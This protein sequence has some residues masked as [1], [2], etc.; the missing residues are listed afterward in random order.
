MLFS[1]R[2]FTRTTP[3]ERTSTPVPFTAC[4]ISTRK[5][6]DYTEAAFTLMVLANCQDWTDKILPPDD[7]HPKQTEMQRKEAL[8]HEIINL[9]D[10]RAGGFKKGNKNRSEG[11][12]FTRVVPLVAILHLGKKQCP[13]LT[14]GN[15]FLNFPLISKTDNRV[16]TFIDWFLYNFS[17]ILMKLE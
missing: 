4:E 11:R 8:Y 17:L 16:V 6:H 2:T 10:K 1:A 5:S 13:V 15:C 14:I 7:K 9:L 3:T 12:Y